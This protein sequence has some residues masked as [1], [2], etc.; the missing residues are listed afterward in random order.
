MCIRD[1][2]VNNPCKTNVKGQNSCSKKPNSI[3]VIVPST[4]SNSTSTMAKCVCKEKYV[5]VNNECKVPL[6]GAEDQPKNCK[7]IDCHQNGHCRVSSSDGVA[8]CKCDPFYT[9]R[10]CEKYLCSGYCLNGG[11]CFPVATNKNNHSGVYKGSTANHKPIFEPLL[12]CVCPDG[13]EGQRCEKDRSSCKTLTCVNGGTCIV[14]RNHNPAC[15]CRKGYEGKTCEKCADADA[16]CLHGRCTLVQTI[17]SKGKLTP[18]CFCDDGFQVSL[19]VH[20]C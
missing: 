4:I 16:P 13:F 2:F 14:D 3:C 9:G 12:K 1:S 11:M 8:R 18:R 20:L 10:Y 5:D 15:L 17:H 6:H 19:S 7:D